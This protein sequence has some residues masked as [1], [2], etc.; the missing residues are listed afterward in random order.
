MRR[1]TNIILIV[2]F[3][4]TLSGCSFLGLNNKSPKPELTITEPEN[5]AYLS[6]K[7]TYTFKGTYANLSSIKLKIGDKEY[8]EMDVLADGTWEVEVN[9]SEV[10]VGEKEVIAYGYR[11]S[12]STAVAETDPINITV[13]N[14][15]DAKNPDDL[16]KYFILDD[17]DYSGYP[18]EIT[19][20]AT[21]GTYAYVSG[22]YVSDDTHILPFL[23]RIDPYIG[24]YDKKIVLNSLYTAG[25]EL[26][27]VL[28]ALGDNKEYL[29]Y[30]AEGMNIHIQAL[31][32]SL[33][34]TYNY[35]DNSNSYVFR[36]LYYKD[37]YLYLTGDDYVSHE[38]LL[39]KIQD[40]GSSFG[41][42]SST[43]YNPHSNGSKGYDITVV[44]NNIY[45]AAMVKNLS[46]TDLNRVVWE[47]DNNLV[48]Q[49]SSNNE[50]IDGEMYGICYCASTNKLYATGVLPDVY[51]YKT[52]FADG[53]DP[54][55]I[56]LSSQDHHFHQSSTTNTDPDNKIK[57][58]AG[59]GIIYDSSTNHA[60]IVGFQQ[61]TDSSMS[62]AK[63]SICVRNG[64]A[65]V[66]TITFNENSY[67]KSCLNRVVKIGDKYFAVGYAEQNGSKLPL[68]MFVPDSFE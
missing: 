22:Y 66:R 20:I 27:P 3:L 2:F 40:T 43:T 65:E 59:K 47:F 38:A 57:D 12:S 23:Y 13:H 1:V 67:D 58:E 64:A 31:D 15:T 60:I 51:D 45:V 37:G 33:N 50:T 11:G 39:F 48:H 26:L 35:S 44:G 68:I 53:M 42:P 61:A 21:D 25:G 56:Y 4:A 55:D 30:S 36:G 5:G 6:S 19:D 10:G 54:N 7:S 17:P 49:A 14:W 16:Y 46:A 9:L 24:S 63:A 28:V 18:A 32:S 34:P 41:E 8:T 29:A 62:N 52:V